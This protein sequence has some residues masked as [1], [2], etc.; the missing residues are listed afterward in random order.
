LTVVFTELTTGTSEL[1]DLAG[2]FCPGQKVVGAMAL[3]EARRIVETGAGIGSGG[4][5]APFATTLVGVFCIPSTNHSLVDFAG[6]FPA[7]GAF[8]SVGEIDLSAVIGLSLP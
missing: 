6:A 7:P 2:L 1:A 4:L 5:G 8:S 3:P